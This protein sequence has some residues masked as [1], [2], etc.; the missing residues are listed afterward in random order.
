MLFNNLSVIKRV[1][2][3]QL[4]KRIDLDVRVAPH[5]A[6]LNVYRRV[7]LF[8]RDPSDNYI[9]IDPKLYDVKWELASDKE[10]YGDRVHNIKITKSSFAKTGNTRH[11]YNGY[12]WLF[13]CSPVDVAIFQHYGHVE[14]VRGMV[15]YYDYIL[16]ANSEI[17]MLRSDSGDAVEGHLKQCIQYSKFCNASS[18]TGFS[19]IN[20]Y[21]ADGSVTTE[22]LHNGEVVGEI[23]YNGHTEED[24][25]YTEEDKQVEGN[26][27]KVGT[28][29][30]YNA[31]YK[32]EETEV[33]RLARAAEESARRE[34]GWSPPY[35]GDNTK[36]EETV[37]KGNNTDVATITIQVPTNDVATM[38]NML[39]ANGVK[40]IKLKL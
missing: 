4:N 26:L 27:Y 1:A 8:Y 40:E 13:Q 17:Y 24:T 16:E 21:H 11:H 28:P 20:K 12:N 3:S 32:G 19:K 7:V 35:K 18:K 34:F 23:I 37:Y 36:S 33:E 10:S 38:I 31:L 15:P 25:T 39:R 29:E 14:P 22:T 6:F 9:A 2:W 30:Y 5:C